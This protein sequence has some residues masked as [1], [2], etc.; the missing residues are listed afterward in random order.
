VEH[1]QNCANEMGHSLRWEYG[2][3]IQNFIEADYIEDLTQLIYTDLLHASYITKN[4]LEGAEFLGINISHCTLTD[5]KENE[6]VNQIGDYYVI[7]SN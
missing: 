7:L 2:T 6:Y 3:R 5:F 4:W 1:L